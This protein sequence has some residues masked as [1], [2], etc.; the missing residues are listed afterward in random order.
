[1]F[2]EEAEAKVCKKEFGGES[3]HPSEKGHGK[4]SARWRKAI[5]QTA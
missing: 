5:M 3:L 1:M 4:N 2:A